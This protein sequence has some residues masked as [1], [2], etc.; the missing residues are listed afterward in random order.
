MRRFDCSRWEPRQ[1]A[2][3]ARP[4]RPKQRSACAA[5]AIAALFFGCG[6]ARTLPADVVLITLDTT[7]VDRVGAYGYTLE[8][9]PVLDALAAQGVRYERAWTTS[10][11]TLPSHGSL[12]TGKLPSRHGATYRA[13]DGEIGLG[14]I[15]AGVD[16]RFRVS[17]LA[18]SEITL[19]ELVSANGWSTAAFV[20]GPWLAPPFGLLQGYDHRDADVADLAGRSAE[21]ITNAAIAWLAGVPREQP[22]HV[23]LNY[24]DPHAPYAPPAGFTLDG[25]KTPAARYD[26]E[27]RYMDAQIGRLF[28]A[29]REAGRFE[30]ALVVVVS[31]HGELFG[32]H[33]LRRHGFYLYEELLRVPL[34]VK[35]PGAHRAGE[36]STAVVSVVDVLPLIGDVLGLEVPGGLDGQAVGTRRVAFGEFHQNPAVDAVRGQRVDRDL[37]AAIEW[38]WKLISSD[39]GTDELYRLDQDPGEREDR[40]EEPSAAEALAALSRQVAAARAASSV[41]DR[42]GRRPAEAS[43]ELRARLRAL[44]YID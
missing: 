37:I 9:T 27:I 23:L 43:P 30:G 4:R 25:A 11:W 13:E 2:N 32:E 34:L 19:A 16:D 5:L 44:G 18:E 38:P 7:R 21:E 39:D 3:D 6:E 22:V 42:E 17:A 14:E 40:L 36:V 20:A 24:F 28:D 33:G 35:H 41:R 26:G 10:P 1:R 12:L 8:T 15:V 31:D 29:L